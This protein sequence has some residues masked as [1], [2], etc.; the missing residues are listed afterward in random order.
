[1]TA[2]ARR[3]LVTGAGRGIGEAVAR[4]LSGRGDDVLVTD[5]DLTAARAVADSIGGRA[6]LLDVSDPMNVAAVFADA[7]PIDVLI[8]NAGY[9]ELG[10]FTT[11]PTD[12]WRPMIAVNLE[13]VLL[14]SHAALTSMHDR[15]YGRIVNVA[16]EAARMGG[17][18]NAVYSACKGAVLSFT[19]SL[20]RE[21][22]RFGVTVNAVAPGPIDTPAL[23]EGLELGER[24]RR[25]IDTITASTELR[26]LGTADE[27]AAA[28]V[29]LASEQAGYI[30]GEVL[31][32]SGGMWMG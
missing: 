4:Q 11:I 24:G 3:A 19:R 7:G 27:V 2:T 26:R 18:G 12:R 14:C 13:G 30:T 6:A 29:F 20:A 15:G 1:M 32:V 23:W 28:V 8:N 21:S 16:S 31:G 17:K 5:I 22:A 10:F 25:R 9:E